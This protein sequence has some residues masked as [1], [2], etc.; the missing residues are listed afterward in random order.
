MTQGTRTEEELASATAKAA[1]PR[2][3]ASSDRHCVAPDREGEWE[4]SIRRRIAVARR[5]GAAGLAAMAALA[6]LGGTGATQA[7]PTGT[8]TQP[9]VVENG[10]LWTTR[11]GLVPMCWH[12]LNGF[13]TTAAAAAAQ[14]FVRTA[15]EAWWINLTALRITW[16]DCPTS[17]EERHVRVMLRAGD[18][19]P[20]GT[21]IRL[22]TD[23]LSN[24]ADRTRPPPNDP[25]GLLMGFPANWNASEAGRADLRALTLHE[26]GHVLGFGH[27]QGR[28]DGPLGVDC[29]DAGPKGGRPIGPRPDP[30]SIMGWSYCATAGSALSGGDIAGA[31]EVYGIGHSFERLGPPDRRFPDGFTLPPGGPIS[32]IQQSD[33]A[34]V[35][36]AIGRD[37]VPYLNW[38]RAGAAW[39]T[40]ER[41]AV[42]DLRFGDGF[43]LPPGAP[44]ALALRP[45]GGLVA[46]G[47]GKDG[48]PYISW[49]QPNQPWHRFERIAAHDPRFGDGF[50]VAPGAPISLAA[51]R[52]GLLV[53]AVVGLDGVPYISRQRTGQPW[54]LFER[55][56]APDPRFGDGFRVQ[57]GA[58]IALG[59]QSNGDLVATVV[60]LDGVPY[61]S[62]QQPGPHWHRFERIG[63]GVRAPSGAPMALARQANGDMVAA[64]VAADGVPHIA[65]QQPGRP[66]HHFV[67]IAELDGR[68]PDG[69]TVPPGAPMTL[70]MQPGGLLAA[71]VVGR[72]GVPYLSRQRAGQPWSLFERVAMPDPRFPDGFTVPPGAPLG[73]A[74]SSRDG[75]IVL[76]AAVGHDGVPYLSRVSGPPLR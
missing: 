17:G 22:G 60:G 1:F 28:P 44:I 56:A 33:G 40:F 20:N 76:G 49:Q 46:A 36:A 38:Q 62:W 57:P 69:F 34:M 42:H 59:L 32:L 12:Q 47:V 43:T 75:N 55:I 48:V 39:G 73:A 19:S 50:R 65:W 26:F 72:D 53:A 54:S 74:V 58:P 7:Q 68:F 35:A 6:A 31:R 64:V 5:Y 51:G 13:A 14:A 30:A 67:R 29:Y 16:T 24:A 3:S 8:I 23:T 70:V 25:P 2:N 71:L 41:M 10:P 15:I 66:W 18:P 45:G 27:E 63:D 9:L 11:G 37:G 4:T 61:I 21:T 52:D